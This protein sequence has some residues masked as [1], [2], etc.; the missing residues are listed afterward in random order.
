M[1]IMHGCSWGGGLTGVQALYDGRGIDQ[2]AGAQRAREVRV[3]IR[4]LN[5][6]GLHVI[7]EDRSAG[8][9]QRERERWW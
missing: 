1:C 5:P 4:D 6:V 7:H 3:H 8:G 2:V 9:T